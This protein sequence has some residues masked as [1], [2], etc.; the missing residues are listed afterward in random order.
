[1]IPRN[2]ITAAVALALLGAL[3]ISL[4]DQ[5]RLFRP[6]RYKVY[7]L[8]VAAKVSLEPVSAD[9]RIVV[10]GIDDATYSQAKFRKPTMLWYEHFAEVIEALADA[11]A[12]VVALD[13][14]LPDVMFDDHIPGYSRRWLKAFMHAR[15]KQMPLIT[16]YLEFSNQRIMP[17]RNYLQLIGRDHMGS[18]NLTTDDD[19]FIRRHRLWFPPDKPGGQPIPTFAYAATR[20]FT[21][22]IA[23]PPDTI[24]I[25][26]ASP[27]PAFATLSFA[28]VVDRVH[29][30]D[31]PFLKRHFNGKLV[32]IGSTDARNQDRQST[33]MNYLANT[34]RIKMP[35]VI[36]HANVANT[37][38]RGIY[39]TPMTFGWNVVYYL[40]LALGA[41][42]MAMYGNRHLVYVSLPLAA[43]AISVLAL[44]AF[45]NY[46]I[47]PVV[48]PILVFS[49]TSFSSFLY[50]DYIVDLEKRRLR[51]LFQ[52]YLP[53]KIV[54]Q[55]LEVSDTEFFSGESKQLCILFSDVRGFT[56]YSEK[57]TPA[58]IVAR[59]NEYFDA[60]AAEVA[61]NGGIVD[62]FIGDGLLAF[63]GAV[64]DGGNPSLDAARTAIGMQRRLEDLNGQWAAK[65]EAT[66]RIGIG[67]HR[68]NVMVGNIGSHYKTEFTVIGDP[69]NLAARLES[70]TKE[71]EADILVSQSVADDLQSITELEPKGHVNIKGRSA[72]TV[73]ELIR[74]RRAS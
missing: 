47:I 24:Y 55:L 34:E 5:H 17:H 12:G 40:L 35:G 2:K 20:A 25:D 7:D 10:I 3:V 50:R 71:L 30:K 11:G 8:M 38:L 31:L 72:E 26:W 27:L 57:R 64:G 56:T 62:K 58:E 52:R 28:E 15:L 48:A 69:V 33:P 49:A 36:I 43:I 44:T 67:L 70:K 4:M 59:L 39:F 41:S 53:P 73:Y 61:D 29:R 45:L 32:F 51:H 66:F 21:P 74:I 42:F 16:G 1:L 60:M 63:F 37:L 14:L 65:G 23:P 68:G 18:F 6:A 54:D 19:D 13:W 9:P 46:F 22:D